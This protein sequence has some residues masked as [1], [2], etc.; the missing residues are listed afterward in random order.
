MIQVF[1]LSPEYKRLKN[2]LIDAEPEE[3]G[4]AVFNVGPEGDF[5]VMYD[6]HVHC[7]AQNSGIEDEVDNILP[8][9]LVNVALGAEKCGLILD[10]SHEMMEH[11][12][13]SVHYPTLDKD[14]RKYM[15]SDGQFQKK[16]VSNTRSDKYRG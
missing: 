6:S 11:G 1:D 2:L 15:D 10:K 7:H 8:K 12:L 5:F 14:I 16:A 3:R 9:D 13:L 4:S